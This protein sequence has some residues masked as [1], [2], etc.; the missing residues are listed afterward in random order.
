[1]AQAFRVD[2]VVHQA[3]RLRLPAQPI[4]PG[5]RAEDIPRALFDEPMNQRYLEQVATKCYFPATEMFLELVDA[6][7]KLSLGLSLSFVR[8]AQE[9]NPDLMALLTR[10]AKHPNV[11]LVGVEPYHSFLF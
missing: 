8:Q 11:E 5:A 3:R 6:G 1:M 10:L 4:A 2:T 9:W 7:F